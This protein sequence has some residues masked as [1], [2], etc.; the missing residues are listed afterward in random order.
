MAWRRDDLTGDETNSPRAAKSRDTDDRPFIGR[1]LQNARGLRF[2][3]P[4]TW[5]PGQQFLAG[6]VGIWYMSDEAHIVSVGVK[7]EHRSR[8]IGELL[9]ISAIEQ[10][11]TKGAVVVTLEVRAS[12]HT[13]KNLYRK[14]GFV[15]RGLR[16]SYYTDNR[17]DATI[18]TTDPI[19]HPSY[20]RAF[21]ELVSQH[22]RRW[23]HSERSLF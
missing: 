14:H 13:A 12:N 3:R 8:G 23:G 10:A 1:L 19:Q 9:L 7:G 16:K 11:V 17:E 6:F 22:E 18:M 20:Q 4:T 21:H 15:E 2:R 5:E